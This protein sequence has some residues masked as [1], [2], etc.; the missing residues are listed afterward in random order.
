MSKTSALLQH[1][2]HLRALVIGDALLDSYV[3]GEASRLCREGPVPIV[4]KMTE[5]HLPG[6]AANTATNLAALGAEVHFLSLLGRDNAGTLLRNGLHERGIATRWVLESPTGSTL[7]KL[8]IL[9]DGQYIVRVDEGELRQGEEIA[10]DLQQQLLAGLEELYPLCDLVVVSDYCYGVAHKAL[11]KRLGELHQE[12]PK[13]LLIDSK[14]LAAFRKMQATV[15]VPNYAEACKLIEPA[16][17]ANEAHAE[18]LEHVEHLGKQV[19][20]YLRAEHV[21]ITLGKQGVLLLK[22]QGQTCHLPAHPVVRA[23]DIGAGDSF[24]SALALALTAGSTVEEATHIAIEAA[25]VAVTKR[26]TALVSAQELRQRLEQRTEITGAPEN[27]KQMNLAEL[28]ATLEP[29]RQNGQRIV[30]TNGIF[31]ILH[32]GH[33]HLLRQARMQGDVLIV[34]INSDNCTRRLKGE[35]RPINHERERM[36]LVAALDAVDYVLLFDE[37]TPIEL[38]RALRPHIHVKG[39]DYTAQELPEAEAVHAGGGR[40]VILPIEEGKST[41]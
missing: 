30:F 1:F 39:G 27:A 21:A 13:V 28:V 34:G 20:T 7:N 38:I 16:S 11:I 14:N 9:A 19:L 32:I 3:E 25:C 40:I 35:G 22:R 26:W 6:G 31:D 23:N 17:V 33:I 5:L 10:L 41:S 18:D 37:D 4:R 8:R 36:A 24:A 15:V 29:L 12:H 2:S